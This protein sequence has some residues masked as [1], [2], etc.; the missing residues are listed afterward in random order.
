MKISCGLFFFI[1]TVLQRFFVSSLSLIS[2]HQKV[3]LR[4]VSSFF[5]STILFVNC[6]I[7]VTSGGPGTS[8]ETL[9]CIKT[10]DENPAPGLTVTLYRYSEGTNLYSSSKVVTSINGEFRFDD[11]DT[12]L[13]LLDAIDQR[14]NRV[15]QVVTLSDDPQSRHLGTFYIEPMGS[16]SGYIANTTDTLI[17]VDARVLIFKDKFSIGRIEGVNDG[18][19]I[20]TLPPGM[21]DITILGLIVRSD[22]RM[23]IDV[24][25]LE[26]TVEV[27]S[28]SSTVID[29]IDLNE[30]TIL[31]NDTSSAELNLLKDFLEKAGST[32][33][34]PASW[35][36]PTTGHL[37][38]IDV[39]S[40]NKMSLDSA[41]RILA[42]FPGL[43][44]LHLSGFGGAHIPE[45]L[46]TFKSLSELSLTNGEIVAIPEDIVNFKFLRSMR[47]INNKIT[48]LPDYILNKS[49]PRLE[50]IDITG[51]PLKRIE[52]EQQQLINSL[53]DDM[54]EV[55]LA[56]V[57]FAINERDYRAL[58]A[59][60]DKNNLNDRM[61]H[62]Y[63]ATGSGLNDRDAV[64]KLSIS[65]A[66]IS[67]LPNELSDLINLRSLHIFRNSMDTLPEV[68]GSLYSLE[69]LHITNGTIRALP[70][71][72]GR[73]TNLKTINFSNN[74]IQRLPK[75]LGLLRSLKCADFSNNCIDTTNTIIPS[76]CII[77]QLQCGISSPAPDSLYLKDIAIVN[78]IINFNNAADLPLMEYIQC[79]NNR[80]V[81]L[82]MVL[83]DNAS[84]SSY[85][86][87]C[88]MALELDSLKTLHVVLSTTEEKLPV[89]SKI[90]ASLEA[91]IGT[92]GALQFIDHSFAISFPSLKSVALPGNRFS[93]IPE[94]IK[95]LPL[96]VSI[97]LYFNFLSGL[98]NEDSLWLSLRSNPDRR[99]LWD[100]NFGYS[101]MQGLYWS[102]SQFSGN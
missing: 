42:S 73:C 1:S 17:G 50:C 32:Q 97:D 28:N 39:H 61:V 86:T 44:R 64:V 70:S 13:Y 10:L 36:H 75:W 83:K 16:L 91:F 4:S 56:E 8:T 60:F 85:D 18:F 15:M 72:M 76:T 5:I 2:G 34:V 57:P 6:Q 52:W 43:E 30:A 7:N 96:L 78:K 55:V 40:T 65:D 59:I 93:R 22:S 77:D 68:F 100:H 37:G 98:S 9:G 38:S 25:F 20:N 87:L 74:Y 102:E 82:R 41:I 71:Q 24:T 94:P 62:S 84:L 29:T 33:S 95:S 27:Y 21:F 46:F 12:G 79:R 35:F 3:W 63:I 51:N 14:G 80:V 99:V 54:I 49:L 69:N 88:T 92:G 89:T 11:I 58:L 48:T 101:Y 31:N 45:T 19:T 90:F 53:L 66:T 81:L 23:P 47:F 26:S 67:T